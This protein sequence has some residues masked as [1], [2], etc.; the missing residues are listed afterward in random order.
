MCIAYGFTFI[1]QYFNVHEAIVPSCVCNI[2]LIV[3]FFQGLFFLFIIVYKIMVISWYRLS[4]CVYNSLFVLISNLV[5]I[6][7][8]QCFI[9]ED[10][11]LKMLR[12]YHFLFLN[13]NSKAHIPGKTLSLRQETV[14]D[15]RFG[16]S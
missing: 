12:L 1:K 2:T 9:I 8:W 3:I 11:S 13:G 14:S 4:S 15:L 5:Y 16:L 10:I 6:W 7:L